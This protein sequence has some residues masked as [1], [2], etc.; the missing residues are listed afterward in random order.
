MAKGFDLLAA[1]NYEEA[2]SYASNLL[3]T[4]PEDDRIHDTL[5]TAYLA[6]SQ[7][8]EATAICRRRWEVA[9]EEKTF[10]IEHGRHK[11]LPEG[12]H[13]G[14]PHFYAPETWLEK[15]WIALPCRRESQG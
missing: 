1:S 6:T 14:A 5:N 9:K 2:I 8:D 10:Y 4:Y 15:Y 12:D 7:H 13:G 11:R 3:S